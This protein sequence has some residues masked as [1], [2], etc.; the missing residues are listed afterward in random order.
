MIEKIDWH[1]A[2]VSRDNK[3]DAA[4]DMVSEAISL[5]EDDRPNA[6]RRL[7]ETMLAFGIDKRVKQMGLEDE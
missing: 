5:I 3:L 6:A 7:L 2:C 1:K 4:R